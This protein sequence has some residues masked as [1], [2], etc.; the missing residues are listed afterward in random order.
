MMITAAALPQTR[1]APAQSQPAPQPPATPDK[2]ETAS[3]VAGATLLGAGIGWLGVEAGGRAGLLIGM[4]L[5]P[6]GAGLGALLQYSLEGARIGILAG[7]LAGIAAGATL[8]YV[9]GSELYKAYQ[10]HQQA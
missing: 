7:G 8:G 10:S 2:F 1:S 3:S 4:M 6:E 5:C 9:V